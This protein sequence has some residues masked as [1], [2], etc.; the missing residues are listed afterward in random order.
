MIFLFWLKIII[1]IFA[2]SETPVLI[3]KLIHEGNDVANYPFNNPHDVCIDASM[4][5]GGQYLSVAYVRDVFF[6]N[7]SYKITT[8][9]GGRI[10]C[11]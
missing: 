11:R 8:H 4:N 5:C 1:G 6:G 2:S 9:K 3:G 10:I 7:N